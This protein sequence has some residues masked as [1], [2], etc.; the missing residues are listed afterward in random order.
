MQDNKNLLTNESLMKNRFYSQFDLVNYAIN[1]ARD[2]IYTG[3]ELSLSNTT[4]N[5]A[6]EVLYAIAKGKDRTLRQ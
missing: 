6:Y 1:V 5:T 4:K 3:H 2:V